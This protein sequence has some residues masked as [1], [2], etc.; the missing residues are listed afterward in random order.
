MHSNL[1]KYLVIGLFF[2]A[3]VSR[4]ASIWLV[5]DSELANEYATYV[6][7]LLH[8]RGFSYYSVEQT[9]E[10]TDKYL[11]DPKQTFPSAFK[12][13]VYPMFLTLFGLLFGTGK[14]GIL[15]IELFQVLLGLASCWFIYDIT[16][17]NFNRLTAIIAL[18]LAGIYPLLVFSPSQVSDAVLQVFLICLLYWLLFKIERTANL[19]WIIP[20][21][22]IILG[23]LLIARTEMWIYL[24]FIFFWLSGRAKDWQRLT[25]YITIVAFIVVSPWVIRN[26]YQFGTFSFNTSGGLNLWEGQN[27]DAKGVPSWYTNPSAKLSGES[28]HKIAEIPLANDYE[29]L[30]DK[31]YFNEAK[32]FILN[33]P[34][35]VIRLAFYKAFFYW[36]SL[37][38]GIDFIYPNVAS[39]VYW[40]PWLFLLPFFIYGAIINFRSF[41]KLFLF[42]SSFFLGTL[43]VMVFFVLPRYILFILPWVI[44][45]AASAMTKIFVIWFPGLWV[46]LS[47]DSG[48][49]SI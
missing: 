34:D 48:S 21:T 47:E 7:N 25:L 23:I 32:S 14:L 40:L 18:L 3:F 37:Y 45:F 20:L 24:P 30:L 42:Y 35:K 22:G 43:T 17:I 26:Y 29:V 2:M 15:L 8:G 38:P 31:I 9:G 5:G 16:I 36:S 11:L 46:K 4:L 12:P 19:K 33:N 6:P 41:K 44:V 27:Q 13:P 49:G 39:P 28:I 10:I 1:Q